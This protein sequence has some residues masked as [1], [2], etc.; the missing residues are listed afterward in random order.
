MKKGLT[1]LSIMLA[2]A[3]AFFA[4]I[5]P[6]GAVAQEA[7]DFRINTPAVTEI[8]A[9]LKAR[10]AQIKPLLEAGTLGVTQAGK[11]VVRDPASVPLSERQ[12]VAALIAGNSNDQAAL[13]REIAR[14]N[15][16]PEWEQQIA[17]TFRERMMKRVPAGWW[18][19]DASGKWTQQTQSDANA[20]NK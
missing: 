19:Q 11:L 17:D 16:H 5:F 7:P 4:Q 20:P 18:V 3:L 9:S 14:A 8:R 15:G 6:T 12:A 1:K 13:Y 10:F 2:V